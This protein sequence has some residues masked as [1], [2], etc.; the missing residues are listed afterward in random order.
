MQIFYCM[1]GLAIMFIVYYFQRRKHLYEIKIKI[2]ELGGELQ[3]TKEVFFSIGPFDN[4]GV[5]SSIY[6]YDYSLEGESKKGWV[7][8][9]VCGDSWI[10][11]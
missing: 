10:L 9:D 11:L 1:I 3:Y 2:K 5:G 8:F 4:I 7:K 6:Q